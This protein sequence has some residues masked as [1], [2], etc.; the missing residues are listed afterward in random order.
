M[1]NQKK[2]KK[3]TQK[4]ENSEK[5]KQVFPWT[6]YFFQDYWP[7]VNHVSSFMMV[8]NLKNGNFW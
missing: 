5:Y 2:K 8:S 3:Q 4:S 6:L 1:K 7:A